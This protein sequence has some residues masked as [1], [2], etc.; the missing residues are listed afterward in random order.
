MEEIY[1]I[2]RLDNICGFIALL[3]VLLSVGTVISLL[4]YFFNRDLGAGCSYK[5]EKYD[6][7]KKYWL[8]LFKWFSPFL[9]VVILLQIFIPNSKEAFMIW[10]VGGTIDYVQSNEVVKQLP[11]KAIKALD[12]WVD[13]YLE[14]DSIK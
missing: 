6:K 1:W 3:I 7:N 9:L 5:E 2:T 14:T 10:G 8:R 12:L 11:D 4:L 13:N